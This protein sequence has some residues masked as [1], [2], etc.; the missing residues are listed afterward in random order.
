MAMNLQ[1]IVGM[2]QKMVHQ[3]SLGL[4]RCEDLMAKPNLRPKEK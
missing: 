3:N 4:R 2:G 1:N